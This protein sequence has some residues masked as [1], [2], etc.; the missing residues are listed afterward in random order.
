[1]EEEDQVIGDVHAFAIQEGGPIR[2][3]A[4]RLV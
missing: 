4:K 2:A 1:V 3:R